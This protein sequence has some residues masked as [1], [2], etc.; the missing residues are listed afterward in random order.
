[1]I[2]K[3][4]RGTARGLREDVTIDC[5]I[6]NPDKVIVLLNVG[7]TTRTSF[8]TAYLVSV[9]TTNIVVN[10]AYTADYRVYVIL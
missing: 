6:T 9:S 5:N 8:Y 2:R 7:G 4:T 10:T 3:I 1:M